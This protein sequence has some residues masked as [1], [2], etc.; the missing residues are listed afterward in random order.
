MT[1]NFIKKETLMQVFSCEFCK[2][3]KSTILKNICERV[4]L[5]VGRRITLKLSTRDLLLLTCLVYINI[6]EASTFPSFIYNSF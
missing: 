6:S 3:F 1:R 5:V 4:I 2:I